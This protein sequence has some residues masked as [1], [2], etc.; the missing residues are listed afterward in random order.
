MIP[1][2]RMKYMKWMILGAVCLAVLG[3]GVLIYQKSVAAREVKIE[4][5]RK[6]V[7]FDEVGTDTAALETRMTALVETQEE[8][9][10]IAELYQMELLSY[11][12]GIAVY[13]TDHDPQELIKTGKENGYPEISVDGTVHALEEETK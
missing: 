9:D 5:I 8:A 1:V 4:D 2:K 12:Y 7:P 13:L 11:S 6:N 3:A 10:Q